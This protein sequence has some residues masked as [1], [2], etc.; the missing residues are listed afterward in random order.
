MKKRRGNYTRGGIYWVTY[1]LRGDRCFESSH[2]RDLRDAEALL[3]KRRSEI[4]SGG[5]VVNSSKVPRR[6]DL[7]GSYIAQIE[8]PSTR[9]R[10]LGSKKVLDEYFGDVRTTDLNAFAI[11]GFRSEQH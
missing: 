4:A 3:S 1:M 5:I 6:A 11:D 8:G 2:S 10:Y 9:L 7:L